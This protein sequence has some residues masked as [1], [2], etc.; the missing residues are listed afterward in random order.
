MKFLVPNYG[1]HQNPW[2]RGYTPRSPFSLSSVLKWICWTPPTP[3]RKKFLSTPLWHGM[4]LLWSTTKSSVCQ[5]HTF[6]AKAAFRRLA[7]LDESAVSCALHNKCIAATLWPGLVDLADIH[8]GGTLAKRVAWSLWQS[9]RDNCTWAD[10]ITWYLI[11]SKL[12]T[13][14]FST[15]RSQLGSG[16]HGKATLHLFQ[17]H[18]LCWD[19]EY[20]IAMELLLLRLR[21]VL[22]YNLPLLKIDLLQ[23]NCGV[24]R[25]RRQC[26]WNG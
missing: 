11:P 26:F 15:V 4:S 10:Q 24:L 13:A 17:K 25:V 23:T 8:T 14:V 19:Y 2:L 9:S 12:H 18:L 16:R 21:L 5:H 7:S 20:S 3:H 1:C 22:C 6:R